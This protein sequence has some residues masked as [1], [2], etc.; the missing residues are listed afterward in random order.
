MHKSGDAPLNFD[1]QELETKREDNNPLEVDSPVEPH[2]NLITKKIK[3]NEKRGSRSP[4]ST[5][6][7]SKKLFENS[8]VTL[9]S[10]GEITIQINL[11]VTD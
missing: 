10:R 7:Q 2:V 8:N 3:K 9:S 11:A 1:L 4:Y 6:Q 5:I